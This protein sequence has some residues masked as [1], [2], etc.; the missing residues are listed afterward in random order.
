MKP[1]TILSRVRKRGAKYHEVQT[2]PSFNSQANDHL[3]PAPAAK[4]IHS[5]TK[6]DATTQMHELTPKI[7]NSKMEKKL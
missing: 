2:Y 4:A 7:E 3:S 6:N 1:S 5:E